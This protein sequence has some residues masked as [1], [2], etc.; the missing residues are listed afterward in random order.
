MKRYCHIV[1]LVLLNFTWQSTR[2]GSDTA[3]M[4]T[5]EPQY[6]AEAVTLP[7]P[8][9]PHKKLQLPNTL[10]RPLLARYIP[11]NDTV[12][13]HLFVHSSV[14]IFYRAFYASK[15]EICEETKL[16]DATLFRVG[17]FNVVVK[18]DNAWEVVPGRSTIGGGMLNPALLPPKKDM[19][20]YHPTPP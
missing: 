19:P 15:K 6:E 20:I 14:D 7:L 11:L 17:Q 16:E 2:A 4:T 9:F 3:R 10:Q 1:L 5:Q 18:I 8:S 12:G 13:V